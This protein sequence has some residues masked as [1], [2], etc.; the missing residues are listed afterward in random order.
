MEIVSHGF[1]MNLL[2]ESDSYR[3]RKKKHVGIAKEIN[4]GRNFICIYTLLYVSS[5]CSG[6][7][8]QMFTKPQI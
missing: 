1:A 3:I 7:Y 2:I 6:Q 8:T 4:F 5:E